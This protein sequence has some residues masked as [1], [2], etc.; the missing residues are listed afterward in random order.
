MAKQ[1]LLS[2][3]GAALLGAGLVIG[4]KYAMKLQKRK[5]LRVMITGAA[6][7]LDDA[8][9]CNVFAVLRKQKKLDD[10]A[11]IHASGL[12]SS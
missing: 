11:P 12:D 6:G 3:A 8:C 10:V 2:L 4:S 1:Q 5:A 9:I 7:E